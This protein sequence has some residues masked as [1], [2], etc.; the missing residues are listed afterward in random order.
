MQCYILLLL[1][2][3]YPEIRQ[4]L[5]NNQEKWRTSEMC[6]PEC[7]WE[8]EVHVVL[9]HTHTHTHTH[10]QCKK[11]AAHVLM[12]AHQQGCE[13]TL[14]MQAMQPCMLPCRVQTETIPKEGTSRIEGHH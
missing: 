13:R 10:M 8:Q 1:L 5:T 2:E 6:L 4:G 7:T 11:D 14:M 12:L 9:P 3:S